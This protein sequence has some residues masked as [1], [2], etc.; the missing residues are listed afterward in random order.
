MYAS[1]TE[2][3]VLTAQM[4]HVIQSKLNQLGAEGLTNR[5]TCALVRLSAGRVTP[6]IS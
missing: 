4:V 2:T 5:R 3:S 1:F 6:Y